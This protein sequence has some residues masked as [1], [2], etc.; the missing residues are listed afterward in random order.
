MEGNS[1]A[2]GAN[3]QFRKKCVEKQ[4]NSG[5][6]STALRSAPRRRGPRTFGVPWWI[7]TGSPV[8]RATTRCGATCSAG[9]WTTCATAP[10]RATRALDATG[11]GTERIPRLDE[12]HEELSCF[13]WSAAAVRGFIPL[14]VFTGRLLHAELDEMAV[15]TARVARR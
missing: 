10:T 9:W 15:L 2:C 5:P 4:E 14:A 8:R 11:I 7:K 12:T 6:D 1:P 13:G 3:L